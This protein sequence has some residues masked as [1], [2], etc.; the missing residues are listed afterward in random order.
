MADF[1]KIAR[2]TLEGVADSIRR[3]K[4]TSGLIPVLDWAD[5]IESISGGDSAYVEIIENGVVS[6]QSP[7]SYDSVSLDGKLD[8]IFLLIIKAKDT[9]GGI[10]YSNY[11]AIDTSNLPSAPNTL[12]FSIQLHREIKFTINKETLSCK[13]YSGDWY[14]IY[15]DVNGISK[16]SPKEVIDEN[17]SD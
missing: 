7:G 14:D 17:Y 16:S 5:E 6:H 4:G 10:N 1:Y 13:E 2:T 3:K 12:S 11:Y 15:V 8:N 9:V